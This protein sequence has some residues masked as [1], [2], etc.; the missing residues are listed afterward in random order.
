MNSEQRLQ[1]IIA[2]SGLAS[3]RKAELLIQQGRVTVNGTV[4]DR[5]GAKAVAGRDHIKVDGK[6]V[7][8]TSR[9]IYILLNKPKHVISSAADPQGRIKVTD[10]VDIKERIYPVG[11]LDYNTEGLILLTNDGAFSKIVTAAGMQIPK[12]YQVKVKGAPEEPAIAKLRAGIRLKNGIQLARCKIVPIKV[13]TNS[14]YEVTLFQGINRQ[15][16]E[17]FEA[18]GHP[19]LKL[20]RIRIGFLSDQGLSTGKYRFLTPREISRVLRLGRNTLGREE[21]GR[22]ASPAVCV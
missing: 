15:I 14:W 9:K 21:V 5:L 20:R 6:T 4:V 16:R 8:P 22:K 3:R 11:R 13:D 17:M 19:V 7:R 10:L 12:V 1:K 18:V 2:A